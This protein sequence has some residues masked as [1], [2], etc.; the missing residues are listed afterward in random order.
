MY[1]YNK[2]SHKSSGFCECENRSLLRMDPSAV[3]RGNL[4]RVQPARG[5]QSSEMAASG[6]WILPCARRNSAMPSV[7]N[8]TRRPDLQSPLLAT[9][10]HSP[11]L[12]LPARGMS[13]AQISWPIPCRKS[14]PSTPHSTTTGCPPF[15]LTSNSAPAT[16]PKPLQPCKKPC[17]TTSLFL[18][19]NTLRAAPFTLPASA[20]KL[21]LLSVKGK[22]PPP[23]FKNS[24]T[25]APSSPIIPSLG[26]PA[27]ASPAPT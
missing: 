8:R 13:P 19:H 1:T 7:Q 4:T 24:S 26:S 22:K 15:A 2:N 16:L 11:P 14:I 17:L 5:G 18:F 20:A 6:S 3:E 25:T 23:N 9:S 12:P 21:T 10:R 27:S